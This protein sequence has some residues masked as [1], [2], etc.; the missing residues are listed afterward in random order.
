[1]FNYKR[2]YFKCMLSANKLVLQ[3]TYSPLPTPLLTTL[4]TLVR[5]VITTSASYNHPLVNPSAYLF[6]A[7]SSHTTTRI[8]NLGH[9]PSGKVYANLLSFAKFYI[10][11]ELKVDLDLL[12]KINNLFIS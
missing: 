10:A 5:R 6:T 12:F 7:A 4:R 2:S 8:Q 9:S 3:T 1:M 11:S